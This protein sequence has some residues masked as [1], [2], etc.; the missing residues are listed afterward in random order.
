MSVPSI[1]MVGMFVNILEQS[2][3]G[4]FVLLLLLIFVISFWIVHRYRIFPGDLVPVMLIPYKR[5]TCHHH[6]CRGR[7]LF[8]EL[9]F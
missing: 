2:I 4:S 8:V 1:R 7:I 3:T 9:V 6:M 5:C